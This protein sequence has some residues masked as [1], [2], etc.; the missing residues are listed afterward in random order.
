MDTCLR[1]N[2]NMAMKG[3]LRG[4]GD[5]ESTSDS[6][7]RF[8]AHAKKSALKS[9]RKKTNQKT[10]TGET[11]RQSLLRRKKGITGRMAKGSRA[12]STE[13]TLGQ[14]PTDACC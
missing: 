4:D 9:G 7:G 2:C 8:G 1:S 11:A 10:W 14:K 5:Y 6:P 13:K 3:S 12:T